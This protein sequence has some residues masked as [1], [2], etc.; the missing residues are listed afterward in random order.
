M[1]AGDGGI[2][3]GEAKGDSS[4]I[5]PEVKELRQVKRREAEI[6]GA[7]LSRLLMPLPPASL[8][9]LVELLGPLILFLMYK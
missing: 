2:D 3:R 4:F 6:S 9:T 7:R 1:P 5:Q 8:V